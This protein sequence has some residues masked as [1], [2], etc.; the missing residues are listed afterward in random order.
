MGNFVSLCNICLTCLSKGIFSGDL[1]IAKITP[2]FKAGNNTELS[3]YRPIP[4][5]SCFSKILER[6]LYNY[7]C[8]YLLDLNI[9]YKK[10]FAF[11]KEQST[12]HAILELGKRNS[13]SVY[14]PVQS[15]RYCRSQRSTL[16]EKLKV[17]GIVGK[18]LKCFKNFLNSR[19]Q[20]IQIN[21]EEKQ[22]YC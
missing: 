11:Q 10:Q 8:K 19:K 2:I 17:D 18:T 15:I 16:I 12:D 6:V 3:N 4:V 14:W 1:K 13:R 9:F 5:L 21:N 20:Y 22:I 7:S